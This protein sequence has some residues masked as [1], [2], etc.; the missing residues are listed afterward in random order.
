VE[1]SVTQKR[2]QVMR[3][4]IFMGAPVFF[5]M[6]KLVHPLLLAILLN[7]CGTH[8]PRILMETEMGNITLEVYP[9]KAP[10]T[11]RQTGILHKDGVISM[12]STQPGT[13]SSEFFIC[14]GNQPWIR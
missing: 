6:D 8:Y 9:D 13:A 12:A 2:I 4:L 14:V 11:T 10:V 3:I 1:I 5:K 7:A